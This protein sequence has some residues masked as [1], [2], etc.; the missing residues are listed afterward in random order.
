MKWKYYFQQKNIY[1][2]KHKAFMHASHARAKSDPSHR[3]NR[4]VPHRPII[5]LGDFA[6]RRIANPEFRSRPK[7]AHAPFYQ[8][9]LIRAHFQASVP[10][11]WPNGPRGPRRLLRGFSTIFRVFPGGFPA[12]SVRVGRL[13][14][15]RRFFFGFCTSDGR[16]SRRK[17]EV[18]D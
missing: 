9:S 1:F 7:G 15:F 13:W 18:R 14:D 16:P 8:R 2:N 17:F 3:D 10:G 5:F 11:K 4:T 6:K 12:F